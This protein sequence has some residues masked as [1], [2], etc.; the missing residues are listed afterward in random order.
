M[1]PLK[2]FAKE[3]GLVAATTLGAGIF[4]LPY[5]FLKAGW[6]AGLF[7]LVV[8]AAVMV[9]AHILYF[10]VLQKTGEKNRLL[11]LARLYLGEFGFIVGLLAILCGL[12]LTLV[13]YLILAGQFVRLLF[14]SVPT[15]LAAAC[16]WLAAALPLLLKERRSVGLEVLGII[17]M[18][19]IIFFIFF[20]SNPAG[21]LSIVSA[22]NLRSLFLPFGAVLFALAGWTAVE[23]VFD[24]EKRSKSEFTPAVQPYLAL[25]AGTLVAAALYLVFVVG[26]FGSPGAITPDTISGLF[27][28]PTYKLILLAAL[29]L[30]AIWTS[31]LPIGLEIKH[32]FENDLRLRH[33]SSLGLVIFLPPILL[34]LGLNN[35]SRVIGLV[36]GVFLT[37]QYL[38]IILVGK[39]VLEIRGAKGLFLN[40]LSFVF[41]LAAVYEVYYFVVNPH[42]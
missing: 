8:L 40:L 39:K 12:I 1:G 41:I 21:A 30:F 29:G 35:F 10:R 23:P 11:G 18:A 3:A 6:L 28:W 15:A 14:P 20:S 16:F 17:L 25:A 38:L 5:V 4:A 27:G 9:L 13:I 2:S 33:A 19:G 24:S 31:Y 7:Y 42:T 32:S 22:L 37:L 34:F 36:G 26:I